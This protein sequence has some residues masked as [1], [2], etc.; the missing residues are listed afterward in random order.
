MKSAK[1]RL[2]IAACLALAAGAN[3]QVPPDVAAS[4][5]RFYLMGLSIHAWIVNVKP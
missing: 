5:E 2:A 3:A 1:A 4:R